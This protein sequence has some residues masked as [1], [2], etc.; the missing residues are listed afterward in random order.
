[1]RGHGV[2]RPSDLDVPV[3]M[4]APRAGLEELEPL[5]RQRQ[6]SPLVA[7]QE[8][9]EHLPAHRAVDPQPRDRAVPVAQVLVLLGEAVEARPLQRVVLDVAAASLLLTVLPRV[10][11]AGRKRGEAPVTRE[12]EVHL[13]DIR[14][15]QACP[16]DGRLRIIVTNEAGNSS[17]VAKGVLVKSEEALQ[18]L[19]SH[20]LLVAV[21][22]VRERHPE[23]PG[24][25]PLSRVGIERGGALEEVHLGLFPRF[26]MDDAGGANRPGQST[27][28][29]LHR[30]VATRVAVLLHEVLPDPL[31]VQSGVELLE[32]HLAVRRRRGAFR[33]ARAGEHFGR[34]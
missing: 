2:E 8:V 19:I 26:G 30:L 1:M 14:V 33:Q 24:P 25:P 29:S 5:G 9:S 27:D 7:L 22:R 12:G 20:G 15:V 4:D 13:V 21:S 3:G 16:H 17:E 31:A 18:L 28:E 32:D 10:P 23:H 6:E 11:G 34:F